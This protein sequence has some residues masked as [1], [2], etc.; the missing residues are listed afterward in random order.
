MG[1]AVISKISYFLVVLLVST[2]LVLCYS[3]F[4]TRSS[5]SLNATLTLK[6]FTA[7]EQQDLIKK[8]EQSAA[9]TGPL[10]ASINAADA[11]ARVLNF[12]HHP[13]PMT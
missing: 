10:I 3:A 13:K 4:F 2:L 7:R 12:N 1:K 6:P 9:A 8:Q 11:Q 5:V